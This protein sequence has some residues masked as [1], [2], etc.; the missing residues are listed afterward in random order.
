MKIRSIF[1]LALVSLP[2]LGLGQKLSGVVTDE[3]FQ[4]LPGAY[5]MNLTK[6]THAHTDLVGRFELQ[7][8]TEDTLSVSYVG[9]KTQQLLVTNLKEPI[10]IR[11]VEHIVELSELTVTPGQDAIQTLTKIDLKTTPV[12]SSQQVLRTVPG[13][14]IGQHAG[15]GKA[16]QIFLRG[17]DI[18]HG[19]DF[20]M[21]VDG[22][23][24]NMV[25]HAHGQG[26]SDLHFLIPELIQDIDF[27][28]GP[29]SAS[30]GNFTTAGYANIR[31]KSSL[32]SSSIQVEGG[33]FNT[34][35]TVGLF[36]LLNEEDQSAYLA[37]TYNLSDGPFESSQNF[38]RIN[39]MGKYNKRL[40]DDHV[41]LQ[42]THFTSRWTASGQIPQRA[43]DSGLI[44]R[45]GA[46][47][48]TEGG[49]TSRSNMKLDYVKTIDDRTFISNELYYGVYD[50]ELYSNF[51]F[52]LEDPENGDQIRQKENRQI[53][54][55]RSE[56]NHSFD[57][58]SHESL[59][60][61]G[62][63]IRND[64]VNDNELSRTANRVTTLEQI[65]LGDVH[66]TNLSAYVQW[67]IEL[68]RWLI[69]PSVR[70]DQFRFNYD[71]ALAQTQLH[72]S[73]GIAS[74]KFNLLYNHSERLQLYFKSG[75]GFHSNDARAIAYSDTDVILPRAFGYDL[76]FIVKPTQQSFLNVAFWSLKL[77]QE[78]VYVGDAGIVERGG[79]THRVGVDLSYRY[80]VTPWLF[81]N[82]DVNYTHARQIDALEGQNYVPLAPG[83][84]ASGGIGVSRATGFYGGLRYRYMADRPANEDHSMVADGY[85]VVDLNMGYQ[86]KNYN[87]GVNIENLFNTDWNETQFATES[88]LQ[89]EPASVEEIHFTPG[90]PFSLRAFFK[91]N[92]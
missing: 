64:A 9:F 22:M 13:L 90:T 78:L 41:S 73:E 70:Y 89:D 65:Q 17:F 26:Y 46:I 24:V 30:K 49:H 1:L 40:G 28:K 27:G 66:E 59:L 54:M 43:I 18:D 11:L 42:F 58:G 68:G 12:T 75:F 14:M 80:Q 6:G 8:T 81:L 84:T 35:R 69:S 3:Q 72:V 10:K 15:G 32:K 62:G 33:Q 20:N 76:G 82:Q 92:F 2:L 50:F 63:T 29:Y 44:G 23:P 87:F 19:T 88:R 34:L 53:L 7:V 77:Q 83:L 16:E 21:S 48:D 91:V 51:T 56:W 45:F 74:P 61:V 71:D 39:L 79:Q 38:S 31:T 57:L 86:F 47:D 25:S 67:D 52:F 36:N 37:T 60:K 55:A 4:S 5:V 85:T